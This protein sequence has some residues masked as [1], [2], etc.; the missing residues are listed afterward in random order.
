MRAR[1]CPIQGGGSGRPLFGD[2]VGFFVARGSQGPSDA[3]R[4]GP[5]LLGRGRFSLPPQV[6]LFTRTFFSRPRFFFGLRGRLDCWLHVDRLTLIW[7]IASR[8]LL[9]EYPGNI[10]ELR[11]FDSPKL[12]NPVSC[13]VFFYG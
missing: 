12:L 6:P 9:P 5:F 2:F 11:G 1:G 8:E 10:R 4:P 7:N 3:L 13:L